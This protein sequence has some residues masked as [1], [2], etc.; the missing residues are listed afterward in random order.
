[1]LDVMESLKLVDNKLAVIVDSENVASTFFKYKGE[2][3]DLTEE[4]LKE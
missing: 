4:L 1:M 3:I 2:M